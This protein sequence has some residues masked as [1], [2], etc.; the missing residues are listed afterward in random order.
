MRLLRCKY[1]ESKHRLK[2][3]SLLHAKRYCKTPRHLK[4][5]T[6]AFYLKRF[7]VSLLIILEPYRLA[8]WSKGISLPP[9]GLNHLFHISVIELIRTVIVSTEVN[10]HQV[11][12]Q[13]FLLFQCHDLVINSLT[14]ALV[15]PVRSGIAGIA[16]STRC[17]VHHLNTLAL[18]PR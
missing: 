14:A 11:A 7:G 4:Q 9:Q 13:T 10:Q 12:V 17:I 15:L 3:T 8:D 16:G 1:R 5:N 18:C 6:E 2:R